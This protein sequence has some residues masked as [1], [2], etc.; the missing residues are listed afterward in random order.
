MTTSTSIL[1]SCPN[2]ACELIVDLSSGDILLSSANDISS[3]STPVQG[4]SIVVQ[5]ATPA[6]NRYFDPTHF[7]RNGEPLAVMKRTSFDTLP[8]KEVDF[9]PASPDLQDKTKHI[10]HNDLRNRGLL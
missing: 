9:E 10:H 7:D 1:G 3:H 2:C 6:Y 4:S 5:H 8:N